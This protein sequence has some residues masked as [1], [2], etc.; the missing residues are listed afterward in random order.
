MNWFAATL[1]PA[2]KSYVRMLVG[3]KAFGE[4]EH[5]P[6]EVEEARAFFSDVLKLT[7][8]MLKGKQFFCTGTDFTIVD[9]V[10]YNEISTVLGLTNFKLTKKEYPNLLGWVAKMSEVPQVKTSEETFTKKI[11]IYKL[12]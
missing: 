8:G 9:I 3:P 10:V 12:K 1:R 5:N 4:P 6:I 11:E 2:V 7:D